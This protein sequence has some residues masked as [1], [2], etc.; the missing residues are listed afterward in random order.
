MP[1]GI[2]LLHSL[3]ALYYSGEET[4]LTNA[5]RH[6]DLTDEHF[7]GSV[8]QSL[9]VQQRALDD[10]TDLV[11]AMSA[12]IPYPCIAATELIEKTIIL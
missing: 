11:P 3:I 10:D 5:Y 7:Y 2:Y 1:E 4:T 8:L 9:P 12:Y 6:A